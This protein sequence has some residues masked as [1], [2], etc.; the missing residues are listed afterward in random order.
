[1][2]QKVVSTSLVVAFKG[3]DQ[4]DGSPDGKVGDRWLLEDSQRVVLPPKGYPQ[5]AAYRA[6]YFLAFPSADAINLFP[7]AG[8]VTP[9]GKSK[10]KVFES[11]SFSGSTELRVGLRYPRPTAVVVTVVGKLINARHGDTRTITVV[12]DSLL[13]VVKTNV[14]CI[15]IVKVEYFA[16]YQL[17]MA[18]FQPAKVGQSDPM[19]DP[20]SEV[21][22][23]DE[24]MLVVAKRKTPTIDQDADEIV[25]S[26]SLT[27]PNWDTEKSGNDN[28]NTDPKL[29]RKGSVID[30]TA[31]PA[32]KLA[33][34]VDDKNPVRLLSSGTT[35]SAGCKIIVVPDV[36]AEFHTTSGKITPGDAYGMQGILEAVNFSGSFS[37]TLKYQPQSPI[38]VDVKGVFIDTYGNTFSPNIRKPGDTVVMVTW[39]GPGQFKDPKPRVVNEDEI[40][41]ADSFGNAI[42]CY[43]IINVGYSTTGRSNDFEFDY[44]ETKREFLNAWVIAQSGTQIATLQLTGPVLKNAGKQP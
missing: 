40:V 44:D 21:P 37:S 7:N 18:T 16:P 10:K 39:T 8:T 15:G 24:P 14:P 23:A 5:V 19:K 17:F 28:T 9:Q 33:M 29:K 27:P 31:V 35:L 2:S 4:G 42:P 3:F 36:N 13:N 30:G 11:L 41:A 22:P 26:I 1:M 43:G 20:E 34:F 12:Y 32:P 38:T 6:S 25:A